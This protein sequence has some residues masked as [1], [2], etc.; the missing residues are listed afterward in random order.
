MKSYKNV[1]RFLAIFEASYA[2]ELRE[3][4]GIFLESI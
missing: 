1:G 4:L 2:S 3:D